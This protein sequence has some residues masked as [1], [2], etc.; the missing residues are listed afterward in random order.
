MQSRVRSSAG[1]LRQGGDSGGCFCRASSGPERRLGSGLEAAL[2]VLREAADSR[3]HAVL[4][5]REVHELRDAQGERR[6]GEAPLHAQRVSWVGAAVRLRV[7]LDEVVVVRE[8][9]APVR[10]RSGADGVLH[11][12]RC[13]CIVDCV[14]IDLPYQVGQRDSQSRESYQL[15]KEKREQRTIG[16]VVGR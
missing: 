13:V 6:A 10:V 16:A 12:L 5:E 15:D 9:G 1:L 2:V 11:V 4:G 3:R 7:V 8:V 14:D